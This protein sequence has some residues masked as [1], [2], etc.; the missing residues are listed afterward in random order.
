MRSKQWV[1]PA[2]LAF[3]RDCSTTPEVTHS[4]GLGKEPQVWAQAVG[5][6][7]RRDWC[8]LMSKPSLPAMGQ[9]GFRHPSIETKVPV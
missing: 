9:A 7:N 3:E 1:G 8:L 6:D 5:M 4:A 2:E